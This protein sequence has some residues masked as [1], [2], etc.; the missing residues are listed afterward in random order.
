MRQPQPYVRK[1]TGSWYVQI[2]RKQILLGRDK[3]TAFQRYHEIM[4]N[5]GRSTV[6][7]QSVA[8]LFDAYPKFPNSAH[9]VR[10]FV[11]GA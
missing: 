6:A 3:E 10:V 9:V 11:V 4:A 2:G 8:H 1:Q 5:R 7:Y